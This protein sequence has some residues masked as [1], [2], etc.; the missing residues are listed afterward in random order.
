MT[1]LALGEVVQDLLGDLVQDLEH[2]VVCAPTQVPVV[3]L[4][5]ELEVRA[6]V[7]DALPVGNGIG[8]QLSKHKVHHNAVCL[9]PVTTGGGVG[10]ERGLVRPP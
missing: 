7:K 6:Q 10:Q 5:V 1:K 8:G 2:D 9:Q 4:Q 3:H